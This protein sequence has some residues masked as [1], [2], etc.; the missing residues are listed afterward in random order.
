MR[1]TLTPLKMM[2]RLIA[3]PSISSTLPALN[4]SN[5]QV[6]NELATWLEEDGYK[7][8]RMPLPYQHAAPQKFNLIAT[9]GEGEGNG[10][11]VLSGHTDTVPCNLELWQQDPF[12][13]TERD[14]KLYGLGSTDMKSFLA[15]AIEAGRSF[16]AKQLKEPLIILATADE[17]STMA[18]AQALVNAAKPKAR[19]AVIGE[20]TSNRPIRMHKGVMTER[21]YI[22]GQAGHSSDPSLG[23]NALEGMHRVISE[24]LLIRQELQVQH[25]NSLFK[26][27]VSTMNLGHIHGGDNP[28]RICGDCLLD[29]DLR[30]LPGMKINELRGL[31]QNRLQQSL[32]DTGLEFKMDS[33][34]S[35]L[36]AMETPANSLLT[37]ITE[38]LTGQQAGAVAF[39]TEAPYLQQLGMDVIVMGPGQIDVAHQPDEYIATDQIEPTIDLLKKLIHQHCIIGL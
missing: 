5:A 29:I 22:T 13:L 7:I 27:P 18:G 24:L 28:N 14:N 11:L 21:I 32:A 8:E 20:P 15:L 23:S 16:E 37:Q 6:I 30:P 2:Q 39:G 10:G 26:I 35:G 36:P 38:K 25:Q 1:K 34:F 31:L 17:E 4:Q 33:F 9:K 12:K 19:S 3:A